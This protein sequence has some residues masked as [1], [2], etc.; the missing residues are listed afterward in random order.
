LKKDGELQKIPLF[1]GR[2]PV[3]GK[4]D[5]KLNSGRKLEHNGIKIELLGQIGTLCD[6]N[7]STRRENAAI[8]RTYLP[9]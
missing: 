5:I 2:D 7:E 4:V 6:P 8:S 3:C 1:I 9:T